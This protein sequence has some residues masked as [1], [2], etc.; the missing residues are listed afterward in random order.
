[1]TKKALY[2]DI[3]RTITKNL[4][5]FLAI[6]VMAGLGIGVFS[7]FAAGCLDALRAA[8]RFYDTQNT[9]D[10]QI[11]STL[12][13]TRDDLTA[14]TGVDGV[15]A[16]FGSRS[17]DVKVQGTESRSKLASLMTLDKNGMNQ[18]RVLEGV[19]PQEAGQLAVNAKFLKDNHLSLGDSITLAASDTEEKTTDSADKGGE[20]SVTIA[21]DSSAPALAVS[22]YKITAVILSPLRISAD[23]SLTAVSSTSSSSDYLLFAT[24]DCISGDVYSAIYLTVKGVSELDC[25]DKA[26]ETL[27]ESM[28]AKIKATI[29]NSRQQARYD[30]LVGSANSKIADAEKQLAEKQAEVLQKLTDAQ[31]KIDDGRAQLES[32]RQELRRQETAAM[33]QLNSGEQQLAQGR[34]TLAQQQNGAQEQ[35]AGV[36]G[37][38]PEG[39]QVVWNSSDTQ[40]IWSRMMVDGEKA[41]PYLLDTQQ[42]AAPTTEETD[43]YTAAMGQLQE[44]TKAFATGFYVAGVPLTEAQTTALSNLAVNM[45]VL[46]Y[47]EAQLEQNAAVLTTQ[48]AAAETEFAAAWKKIATSETELQDGQTTLDKNRADYETGMAEAQQ[49][50]SDA[51]ADVAAIDHAKWYVWDRSHNDSFAGFKSD[52]SFIQAVT[53]AFPVIFFLVAILISLTT[54]SRMVEE[55]RGLIGT[56]KSLGYRNGDIRLKY[57]LSAVLSCILG[58]M[59]GVVLGFVA[60][61]KAVGIIMSSMY[62]LPLFQLQFYPTYAL[63]GFGL[64]LV[65]ILGA[66]IISCAEM[67]RHRPADLMRPRAPKAGSRI[68][69]ER[70]PF[71]W[72]RLSFL[73]KVTFRNLFRY[74]KRAVMTIVGILGCTMLI[75]FGFGIRDTVGVLM[76]DQFDTVTVYDGI[77]VTDSLDSGGM[78]RLRDEFSS[79]GMVQESLQVQ[80]TA[81]TF[82]SDNSSSDITIVIVPD[83]AAFDHYVHLQNAQTGETMALPE[84]GLVVTQNAAK[85]LEVT[86]GKTVSLQ[87]SDNAAYD[88]Q[89]SFVSTNYAGNFVYM[90]ESLYQSHFGDFAKNAFLLNL[91]DD[92]GAQSWLQSLG[93]DDRI[94][95]VSSNQSARESFK[96]VNSIINMVV[97]ILIGMSA[98]LAVTVLYTLSNINISERDRELATIKVLGFQRNEI[99]A[100]V[101]KETL[102]LSLCGILCG[103]PAGYGITYGILASVSIADI[104]FR[105]RVSPLAYV[106]AAVLTLVFAM[107]VSKFTNR[108]LRKVNMV[109]ALKSVD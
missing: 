104:A 14:A 25:Y 105:V 53:T 68:L 35:L 48:K 59:L 45:G 108:D 62:V 16:V 101:N 19:L 95:S 99:Y 67:L 78:A 51:R 90:R 57:V 88:F 54:M 30:G 10:V 37:A 85:R 40:Q 74:K 9:Y 7:G 52:V 18:P 97:Y 106:I 80:M 98:V 82:Q 81:M 31:K 96:D 3:K 56:Y 4:S 107:L 69:L 12:G 41:A 58:E 24:E 91:T 13:L 33:A 42:G 70:L 65:G 29:Q 2:K 89:V 6:A 87:N 71:I 28:T 1:M 60:L 17:L 5:R 32:G 8:D 84:G 21:S 49:K 22:T 64:F 100:Y 79:S 55:D 103:L 20:M 36:V 50:L 11:V 23:K 73:N 93:D 44:D 63:S 72:K 66:A 92:P 109:E 77:A 15:H 27:T 86:G 102:I 34:D 83:G 43:A 94:L 47:S 46:R 75:V 38:L 76:S 39:A 61:P 26:Y